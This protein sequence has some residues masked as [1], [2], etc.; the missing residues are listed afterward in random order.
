[1]A[2]PRKHVGKSCTAKQKR[3]IKE[4]QENMISHWNGKKRVTWLEAKHEFFEREERLRLY[5]ASWNNPRRKGTL[6]NGNKTKTKKRIL[7]EKV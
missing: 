5:E 4:T 3:E 7:E 2:L 1:M 6:K